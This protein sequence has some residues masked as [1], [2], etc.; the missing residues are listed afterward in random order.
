MLKIKWNIYLVSVITHIAFKCASQKN[1]C[2]N[3]MHINKLINIL[4]NKYS[5][6]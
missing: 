2:L 1:M 5:T 4:F 3:K 6:N